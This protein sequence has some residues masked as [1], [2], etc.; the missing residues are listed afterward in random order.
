M[1][2][3]ARGSTNG[4]RPARRPRRA[5]AA[6]AV[7]EHDRVDVVTRVERQ[8]LALQFF[9]QRVRAVVQ[10]DL[11]KPCFEDMRRVS[12]QQRD[13]TLEDRAGQK[14]ESA[15]NRTRTCTPFDTRT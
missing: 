10:G 9:A 14:G 4:C 5:A 2:S 13:F 8:D 11:V 7:G 3:W 12:G 15:G 1:Q 6:E